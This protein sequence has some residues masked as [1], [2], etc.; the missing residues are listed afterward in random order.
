MLLPIAAEREVLEACLR[1]LEGP[2]M[3]PGLRELLAPLVTLFAAAA[4]ERELA[5]YMGQEVVPAKVRL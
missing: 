5:W 1:C 3:T 4:V 2:S